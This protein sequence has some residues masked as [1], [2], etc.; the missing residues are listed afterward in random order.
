MSACWWVGRN[1][2]FI[3]SFSISVIG[4]WPMDGKKEERGLGL[5]FHPSLPL[6]WQT[7]GHCCEL[8]GGRGREFYL[9]SYLIEYVYLSSF[10]AAQRSTFWVIKSLYGEIASNDLIT[11]MTW[12]I[13]ARQP[14]GKLR[15]EVLLGVPVLKSNCNF[16]ADW[17][18]GVE[19]YSGCSR[20][21]AQSTEKYLDSL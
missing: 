7:H 20:S 16:Q 4:S 21:C 1:S 8:G 14:G 3:F 2:G 9:T 15:F 6:Q 11:Y 19:E 12:V 5:L 10:Q 13:G 17:K 18:T